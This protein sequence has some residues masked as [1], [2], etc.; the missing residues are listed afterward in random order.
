MQN[1]VET[2]YCAVHNKRRTRIDLIEIPDRP[3]QLRC[4]PRRECRP[5]PEGEPVMCSIHNKKRNITQMREV[6]PGVYECLPQYVCRSGNAGVPFQPYGGSAP[7]A[8]ASWAPVAPSNVV[9]QPIST[10]PTQH[11]MEGQAEEWCMKHGKRVLQSTCDKLEDAF[12]ACRDAAICTSTPAESGESLAAKGCDELLCS[13]H[14]TLR[15]VQFLVA[16]QQS[17]TYQCA[18]GHPC[19]GAT[20]TGG[21]STVDF[22]TFA[23]VATSSTFS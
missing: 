13:K 18:D 8:A 3:G 9:V 14:Q 22:S 6:A 1:T 23:A 15:S 20:L 17:Q 10:A 19:S 16:D 4:N 12:Y 11:A 7:V 21:T 5:R 2:G